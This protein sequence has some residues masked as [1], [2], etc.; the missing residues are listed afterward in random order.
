MLSVDHR[1]DDPD[2]FTISSRATPSPDEGS[3]QLDVSGSDTGPGE[4][5]TELSRRDGADEPS[6][7]TATTAPLSFVR[8]GLAR[9]TSSVDI[10]AR[11]GSRSPA[12]FSRE[13]STPSLSF[14]GQRFVP[15][16]RLAFGTGSRPF[17]LARLDDPKSSFDKLKAAQD[18][19][20]SETYERLDSISRKLE[21]RLE[22][23]IQDARDDIASVMRHLEDSASQDS[24]QALEASL[25]KKVERIE[26]DVRAITS[27][28][29][30]VSSE[31]KDIQI[32]ASRLDSK[33]DRVDAFR[34]LAQEAKAQAQ[35][36]SLA[37]E[38]VRAIVRHEVSAALARFEPKTPQTGQDGWLAI[39]CPAPPA[40]DQPDYDA[41]LIR[42]AWFYIA[43][44]GM[45]EGGVGPDEG[46]LKATAE[47][48]PL[49]LPGDIVRALQHV[50]TQAYRR[51]LL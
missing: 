34:D 18:M 8:P 24:F 15:Q 44:L 32:V 19:L 51:P 43:S 21:A 14:T 23:Y 7:T 6:D 48:F 13:T 10:S 25:G 50:H 5:D 9:Q 45:P 38:Q 47:N 42:A 16:K 36:A 11:A 2:H 29:Q 17:K 37:D 3:C 35:A 41:L 20:E 1:S 33:V 28:I 49:L 30:V 31:I 26:A 4:A 40:L 27:S 46:T 22:H 12:S 39:H